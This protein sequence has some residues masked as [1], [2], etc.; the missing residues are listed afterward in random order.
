MDYILRGLFSQLQNFT[1]SEFQTLQ[2]NRVPM[3][4]RV[5]H[6]DLQYYHQ[7]KSQIYFES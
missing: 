7:G 2:I 1:I 6:L 4:V 5:G 3:E